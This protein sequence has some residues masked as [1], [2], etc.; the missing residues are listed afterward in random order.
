MALEAINCNA[1]LFLMNWMIY[2]CDQTVYDKDTFTG[3]DKMGE[4]QIDI[5]PYM[6]CL[7]W[8]LQN[9]PDGT[10]VNRVQPNAKN[11]LLEESTIIW[12]KGKMTQEMFIKLR[13][14]ERGE[15]QI[16]IEWID[17]KGLKAI[18]R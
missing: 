15:V 1:F 6:E 2:T 18:R 3:D 5:K 4:A 11:C 17:V 8:G 7:E 10:K 12:N 9:L 13:N 16:Q 14:V